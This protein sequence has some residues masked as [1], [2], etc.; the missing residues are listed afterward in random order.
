MTWSSC[1]C[2]RSRLG[3][4]VVRVGVVAIASSS[5]SSS[6]WAI[7][8]QETFEEPSAT[9][10]TGPSSTVVVPAEGSGVQPPTTSTLPGVE[11]METLASLVGEWEMAGTTHRD[12]GEA[13]AGS[14]FAA[15]RPLDGRFRERFSGSTGPWWMRG[16]PR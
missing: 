15:R 1:F 11:A 2:D 12:T 14:G 4:V 16:R 7:A 9:P 10:M 13:P 8:V 3:A 5:A 6:A